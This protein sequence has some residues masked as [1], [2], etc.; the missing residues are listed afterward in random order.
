LRPENAPLPS[1]DQQLADP[2]VRARDT[3]A[4][5][6]P[7]RAGVRGDEAGDLRQ[8]SLCCVPLQLFLDG[9]RHA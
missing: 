5:L 1:L 6:S 9:V 7:A 3:G 8:P 4:D 2:L